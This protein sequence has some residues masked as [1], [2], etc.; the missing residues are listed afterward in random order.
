MTPEQEKAL[1]RLVQEWRRLGGRTG[2]VSLGEVM[3]F[4][5]WLA[6]RQAPPLVPADD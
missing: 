2:F 6:E 4:G 1:Q 5:Q 3:R